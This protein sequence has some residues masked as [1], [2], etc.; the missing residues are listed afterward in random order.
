MSTIIKQ[1]DPKLAN[2]FIIQFYNQKMFYFLSS[3]DYRFNH[4]IYTLY[5]SRDSNRQVIRFVRKNKIPVVVMWGKRATQ[6]FVE[7]LNKINV[8]TL[9]HTLNDPQE[10]DQLLKIGVF[11]IYT[12]FVTYKDMKLNAKEHYWT[13]LNKYHQKPTS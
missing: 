5:A 1:I 13:F 9:V 4:Y 12:D 6:D 7:S 2:R 10:I 8:F 11:G 3:K